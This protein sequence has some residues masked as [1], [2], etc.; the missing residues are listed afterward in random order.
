MEL[1][2]EGGEDRERERGRFEDRKKREWRKKVG[3]GG[4][5]RKMGAEKVGNGEGQGERG[6]SKHKK[7]QKMAQ[8]NK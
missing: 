3:N 2:K 8:V 5:E 6:N 4:G 1:K 7:K